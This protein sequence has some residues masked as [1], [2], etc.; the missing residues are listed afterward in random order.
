[1]RAGLLEACLGAF[2]GIVLGF[3]SRLADE[4]LAEQTG[5]A[6]ALARPWRN[7]F[8]QPPI[9][10]G[11]AGGKFEIGRVEPG[12]RLAGLD[13]GAGI[14]QAGAILPPTR[15]ARSNS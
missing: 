15:K 5:I 2:E 3:E 13:F 6:L 9:G 4:F 10:R 11:G 7:R 14:D 12:Q 8:R 1:L